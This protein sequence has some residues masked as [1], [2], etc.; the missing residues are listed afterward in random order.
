MATANSLINLGNP[1][2][3]AKRIGFQPV[4][5]TTS[6]TTQGSGTGVLRG[7]GNKIVNVTSHAAGGAVTL[8][9]DAEVGDEII[10]HNLGAANTCVVFPPTGGSINAQGA[11]NG[12]AAFAQ[13]LGRS[14]VKTTATAW[15]SMLA[16]A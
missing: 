16:V 8:P 13:N 10:V 7:P 11:N 12:T 15:V 5:V 1:P 6:G 9:S 4:S 3:T 2:E 14:F